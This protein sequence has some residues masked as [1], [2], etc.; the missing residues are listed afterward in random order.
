ML[1][2]AQLAEPD[3][4]VRVVIGPANPWCQELQQAAQGIAGRVQLL[5]D[6]R[7]MPQLMAWAEV[8]IAAGGG[9]CWELAFMGVPMLV[10]VLADNQRGVA[11]GLSECG[12]GVNVGEAADLNP[13][14]LATNLRTLLYDH[15]QRARMS[16]V[17]RVMIDGGGAERVVTLLSRLH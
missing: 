7:N 14:Q 11:K 4:E 8:A 1:A 15:A 9:T 12:I 5:S 10:L 17:G 13:A 16:T 3:L 2:L 6:V